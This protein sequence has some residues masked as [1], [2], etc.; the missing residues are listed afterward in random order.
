MFLNF[1]FPPLLYYIRSGV[2][3]FEPG[4]MH[5]YNEK[6]EFFNILLVFEGAINITEESTQYAIN[7]GEYLILEAGKKHFGTTPSDTKTLYYWVHFQ[8]S[9]EVFKT[10]NEQNFLELTDYKNY[11]TLAK[12]GEIQNTGTTLEQL[13]ELEKLHTYSEQMYKHNQQVIF[14]QLLP[15]LVKSKSTSVSKQINILAKDVALY[16]EA[17]FKNHI[18][19]DELATEF[20]FTSTYISRCFKKIYSLT[21]LDYLNKIRLE[22]AKFNLRNTDFSVEDIA[23][24]TGFNSNTYF[25]RIFTKVVGLTP[26]EYRMQHP[27]TEI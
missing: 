9:G 6:S 2:G 18:S 4:R 25:S 19:Y 26:L 10:K 21:P 1:E 8:V 15:Q 11:L 27:K 7:T 16:L 22:E 20:N 14:Q 3:I 24:A 13:K 23:L 17:N 12:K 5:R